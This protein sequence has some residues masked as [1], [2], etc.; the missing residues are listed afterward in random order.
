MAIFP[1]IAGHTMRP[2]ESVDIVEGEAHTLPLGKGCGIVDPFLDRDAVHKGDRV[3]ICLYPNTITNMIHHWQ[4]PDFD[5]ET[6]VRE[7]DSAAVQRSKTSLAAM[8]DHI[9]LSYDDLMD[10]AARCAEDDG[11]YISAGDDSASEYMNGNKH[12]F[13]RHYEIVTGS[14]VSD[15]VRDTYFSCAC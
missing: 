9:D 14:L 7:I 10:R 13:W 11:G 8:A 15:A 6:P 4:H 1:A 5:D 2:G 3:Y 12:E